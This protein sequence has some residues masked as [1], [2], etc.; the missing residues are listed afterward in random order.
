MLLEKDGHQRIK[1]AI[2]DVSQEDQS[3][4]YDHLRGHG[5][6]SKCR[7]GGDDELNTVDNVRSAHERPA[8]RVPLLSEICIRAVGYAAVRVAEVQ[9]ELQL[10]Y[11]IS[12]STM[13]VILTALHCTAFLP[14]IRCM[15]HRQ[16]MLDNP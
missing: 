5:F 16:Y 13:L 2:G 15:N 9:Y 1:N 4:S 8:V 14:S 12:G 10:L 7:H 3:L 11:R 6:F